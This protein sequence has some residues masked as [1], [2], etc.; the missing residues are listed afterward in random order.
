[1]SDSAQKSD[2][3]ERIGIIY[4]IKKLYDWL[5]DRLDRTDLL[6]FK[7]TI[8]KRF[9]SPLPFL[10]F[11]TFI[12]F[13]ILGITG[14][15]LMLFYTPSLSGAWLSVQLI[16]STI[17]YGAIVRNI[18]YESSNAMIFLALAHMYYNYFSGRFKIRNEIIWVTGVIFGTITILEAFSGYDIILNTRAVLAVSIGVSLN[19]SAPVLGPTIVHTIFG[20]GFPDFILRFYA[21]H[22]FVLP[23]VM[24]VLMLVHFPRNLTFDIPVVSAITGAVLILGGMYPVSLGVQYTSTANV[25]YT[26]PEWYLTSL[27]AFLRTFMPKFIAGI[28][29]PTLFILMFAVI[30]FVDKTKKFSWKDRPFFTALGIAS[31]GQIILTTF[32][33]FFIDETAPTP[34]KALFVDPLYIF[35]AMILVAA[36]C[37]VGT[38]TYLARLASKSGGRAARGKRPAPPVTF[39]T[40]KWLVA[41]LV[42]M[43][44]FQVFLNALGAMSAFASFPNLTMFDLGAVL[45]IFALMF[46]LYRYSRPAG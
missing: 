15:L 20:Q 9:V 29:I 28:L 42:A 19:Y 13:I 46:H 8:P 31:I 35:G 5:V 45:M 23:V 41:V 2:A 34:T 44:G 21:L 10:G 26:L 33:G 12:N 43:F 40:S 25:G 30:P 32:W 38:Y 11:L 24:I 37:F 39:L 16:N 18:H 6:A 17:P 1:M 27:Y 36:L 22:I 4:L 14:A 3:Q 7:I